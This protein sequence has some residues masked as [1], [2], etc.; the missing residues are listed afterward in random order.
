M[1]G[2]VEISFEKSIWDPPAERL[3][4]TW[5]Q[6]HGIARVMRRD[7]ERASFRAV[8]EVP[9]RGGAEPCLPCA[10]PF[11]LRDDRII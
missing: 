10:A 5:F 3:C 2:R 6:E 4:A 1:A 8:S 9:S 11:F 7:G